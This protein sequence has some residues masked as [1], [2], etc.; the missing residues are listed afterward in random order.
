MTA[1][2]SDSLALL[3]GRQIFD[4]AAAEQLAKRY[5]VSSTTIHIERLQV[6]QQNKTAVDETEDS[7]ES[8]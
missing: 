1:S 5:G 4:G 7:S 3:V 6:A 2:L 8:D